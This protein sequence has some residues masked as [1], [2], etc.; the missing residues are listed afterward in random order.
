MNQ[1]LGAA[2]CLVVAAMAAMVAPAWAQQDPA[3]PPPNAP[4]APVVAP[5]DPP[6]TPAAPAAEAP[7]P[8]QD[9]AAATGPGGRP[10]RE[11]YPGT[12]ESKQAI[13]PTDRIAGLDFKEGS[14]R[15]GDAYD[16]R[17]R[18]LETKIDDLKEKVF[19]SKSR[20]VLLKETVLSGSLA[21]SRVVIQHEMRLG[22]TFKLRRALFSLNGSRIFNEVDKNDSLASQRRIEIYNGSI[23]PGNHNLSVMLGFQ[24][25]GF[26]LFSYVEGYDFSLRS[27]CSIPAEE[28]KTTFVRVIAFEGGGPLTPHEERPSVSCEVNITDLTQDELLEPPSPAQ[29]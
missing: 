28:G 19:R 7:A 27:S 5:S 29:P 8:A 16:V 21:G 17:V 26:G 10:L 11:D 6:A 22:P 23:A 18:E 14:E 2:F 3:T 9:T 1:R 12:Q 24:G 13:M 15:P 20:I 4:Q 25:S